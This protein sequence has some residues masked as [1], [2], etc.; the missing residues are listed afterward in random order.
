MSSMPPL[1]PPGATPAPLR[2]GNLVS[3]IRY[4]QPVGTHVFGLACWPPF[5][6]FTWSPVLA[7]SLW[8]RSIFGDANRHEKRI[9]ITVGLPPN[10]VSDTFSASQGG[11]GGHPYDSC[12]PVGDQ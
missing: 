4:W 7:L 5:S 11:G 2:M 6:T 10:R 9:K 8:M 1:S 12:R 3:I